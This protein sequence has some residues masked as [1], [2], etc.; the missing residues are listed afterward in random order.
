MR[1]LA[2]LL[3]AAISL[4]ALAEVTASNAWVRGTVPAQK[5]TGAF[6]SLRSTGA[7]RL[8][9]VRTSAAARA[10]I[11][12]SM[13]HD[14]VMMMHEMDGLALPAGK[15]VEL[16]PGGYHVMLLDLAKP[17]AAGDKVTLT[18]VVEEG[19]RRSTLDVV[20]EVRPLGR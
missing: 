18:L 16:K 15:T 7:A 11:H 1:R 13:M 2:A 20:A 17:L 14:G 9:E 4:P 10:E 19:K 5:S 8:V 3:L 6:M 12:S